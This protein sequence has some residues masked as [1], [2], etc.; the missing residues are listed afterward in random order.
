MLRKLKPDSSG[1]ENNYS[2]IP[3]KFKLSN[4]SGN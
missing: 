2:K 4:S 1:N 3:E